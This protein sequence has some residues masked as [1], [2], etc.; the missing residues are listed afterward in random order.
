MIISA[1]NLLKTV[2]NIYHILLLMMIEKIKKSFENLRDCLDSIYGKF[3]G[4]I[5]YLFYFKFLG[6][7][8]II[9]YITHAVLK[10]TFLS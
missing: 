9:Y 10:L 3:V 7:C 4:S 6:S 1:T 2:L 5:L 8:L